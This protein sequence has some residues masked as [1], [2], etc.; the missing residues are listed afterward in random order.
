[1]P[2]F[3]EFA[4]CRGYFTYFSRFTVLTPGILAPSVTD[5]T[6]VIHRI[7]IESSN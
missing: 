4:A 3:R 5:E 6:G 7:K 2:L 1:M